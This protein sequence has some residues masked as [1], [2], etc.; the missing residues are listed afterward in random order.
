VEAEAGVW[1]FK[2][3]TRKDWNLATFHYDTGL[4]FG[5]KLKKPMHY[6]SDEGVKLPSADDIEWIK[7][8]IHPVDMLEKMFAGGG[9]EKEE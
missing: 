3:K 5:M 8:D 7:P 6:S 9:T 1:R 4:K 2:I